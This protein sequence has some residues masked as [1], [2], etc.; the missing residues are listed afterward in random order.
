MKT[1]YCM[2]WYHLKVVTFDAKMTVWLLQ[3]VMDTVN[4]CGRYKVENFK[5]MWIQLIHWFLYIYIFNDI[6]S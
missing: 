3:N 1:F 4:T 6:I 2:K 5:G